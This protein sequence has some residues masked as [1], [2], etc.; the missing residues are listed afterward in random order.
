M[1]REVTWTKQL[2][3]N[4]LFSSFCFLMNRFCSFPYSITLVDYQQYK[5]PACIVYY[6]PK[7]RIQSNMTL[8][9]LVEVYREYNIRLELHRT[10]PVPVLKLEKIV[11]ALLL[12]LD[13]AHIVTP[14]P[15]ENAEFAFCK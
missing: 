2:I 8:K 13:A 11:I 6:A 15:C 5:G 1:T 4:V 3:S 9:T 10:F 7:S 14:C 12:L